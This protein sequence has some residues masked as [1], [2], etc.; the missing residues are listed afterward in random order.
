MNLLKGLD[1]LIFFVRK[2]SVSFGSASVI[3]SKFFWLS[4]WVFFFVLF[5]LN[6]KHSTEWWSS[7]YLQST[8]LRKQKGLCLL[9]LI[10]YARYLWKLSIESCTFRLWRKDVFVQKSYN[11]AKRYFRAELSFYTCLLATGGGQAALF[12]WLTS[13]LP[14][15]EFT[16]RG[17][18]CESSYN[19]GQNI[20]SV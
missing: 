2:T 6:G 10:A 18:T 8:D 15:E 13:F 16:W 1:G 11:Y 5:F 7:H 4:T 9:W 17:Q 14:D 20:Q 3:T 12:I 19:I